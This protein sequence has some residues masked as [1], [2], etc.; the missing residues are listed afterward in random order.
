MFTALK[1]C[2]G[3]YASGQLYAGT[4][5]ADMTYSVN[6]TAIIFVELEA[7][8]ESATLVKL[9]AKGSPELLVEWA[10]GGKRCP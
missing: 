9:Y 8:G 5:T 7:E 10:N 1:G 3:D 4:G 2:V 6:N